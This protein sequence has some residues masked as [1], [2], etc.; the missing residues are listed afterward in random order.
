[1]KEKNDFEK[2][3]ENLEEWQDQQYS[4]GHYIGT[5]KVPRPILN[6][7]RRPGL[8]LT[9]GIIALLFPLGALIF[10]DVHFREIAFLFFIPMVF[11]IG[12]ILR[13][14]EKAGSDWK[15]K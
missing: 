11:I 12:G 10:S 1:M 6:L 3:M 13:I 5:G 15:S 7:T 4:P 8:L 9:A 14:R 2:D